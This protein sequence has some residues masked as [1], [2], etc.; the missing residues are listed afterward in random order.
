M[1]FLDKLKKTAAS[2]SVAAT[3]AANVAVK[4]T[5]TAAAIG[6]LKLNIAQ[7]E[8]KMKKAYTELG[9]LYYRDHEANAE[10]EL[11]EYLP[12]IQRVAD[13]KEAVEALNAQV[14]AVKAENAKADEP[15][16]EEEDT[17]IYVDFAQVQEEPQEAPVEESVEDPQVPAEP[18]EEPQEAPHVSTEEEPAP[19]IGTL[20]VDISGQE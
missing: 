12:W 8:D 17:S 7:E 11:E 19:T 16:E 6:K 4:Q 1:S 15:A 20:Y 3:N 5:K 18:V 13:A 2:A 14:E 10:P 9:R